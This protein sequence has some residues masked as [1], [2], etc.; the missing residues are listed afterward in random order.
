MNIRNGSSQNKNKLESIR[1]NKNIINYRDSINDF[2]EQEGEIIFNE[3]PDKRQRLLSI[4]LADFKWTI[5]SD[6]KVSYIF[7]FVE[8]CIGKEA[9][10]IIKK[11]ICKYLTL[12]SVIACLIELEELKEIMRTSKNIKSRTLIVDTVTKERNVEKIEI[13]SS[14]IFDIQGNVVGIQGLCFYLPK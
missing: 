5:N 6:G 13:T 7:P 4:L 14:A 11:I 9:S 10:Y 1:A 12:P 2:F 8:N 3:E